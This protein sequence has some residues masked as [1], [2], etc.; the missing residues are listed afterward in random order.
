MQFYRHQLND[1]ATLLSAFA[2]LKLSALVLFLFVDV[3]VP[4]PHSYSPHNRTH[5]WS[6]Y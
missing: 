2:V 4:L 6:N 1:F 3:T 5:F